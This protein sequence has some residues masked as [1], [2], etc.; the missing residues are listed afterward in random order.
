MRR[1]TFVRS[2]FLLATAVVFSACGD[3]DD[4]GTGPGGN[5]LGSMSATVTGDVSESFSGTAFYSGDEVDGWGIYM[6]GEDETDSGVWIVG[7]EGARPTTGTHQLS[8]DGDVGGFYWQGSSEVFYFAEGGTV[9]IT[10]SNSDRV[11]GTFEF[12]GSDLEG[13][14]VVVEGTFNAPNIDEL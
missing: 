3:D 8:M 2:M 11:A 7:Q 10:T 13:G 1:H 6:G 12:T 5:E 9:H 14:S 4:N